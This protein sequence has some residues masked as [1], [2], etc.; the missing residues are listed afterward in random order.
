MP[1]PIDATVATTPLRADEELR[2]TLSAFR[3]QQYVHARR[4][5]R[6]GD[7]WRPGRGLALRVDMLPWLLAALRQAEAVALSEG[8]LQLEDYS[9]HG[10]DTPPAL[11]DAA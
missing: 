1:R 10:L 3:G 6:D 11:E 4:Y 8:L 7:V 5:Y 2:V 9:E